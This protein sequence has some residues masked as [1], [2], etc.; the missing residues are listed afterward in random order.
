M[1]ERKH[2]Q[3]NNFASQVLEALKELEASVPEGVVYILCTCR[4]SKPHPKP[5]TLGGPA[6]PVIVTI[7]DTSYHIRVLSQGGGGGGGGVHL[8]Y[9]LNGAHRVVYIYILLLGLYRDNGK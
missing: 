3:I 9:T 4:T 8:T 5:Y 6:H 7:R 1:H 2:K